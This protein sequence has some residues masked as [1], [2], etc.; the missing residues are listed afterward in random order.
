MKDTRF[1]DLDTDDVEWLVDQH[2]L[3]Y[4]IDQ[5]FDKT[6]GAMVREI[7]NQYFENHN[8]DRERSWVALQGGERVGTIFC[9]DEG[10]GVIQLRML[11]VLPVSRGS[12]LGRKLVGECV[13]FGREKGY[14]VMRLWT[15]K[16]LKAACALYE[17]AGFKCI[18]EEP[19]HAF[20]VDLVE[21]T[22]ELLLQIDPE[23]G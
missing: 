7:L 16:N 18:H 15:F 20:G 23:S 2:V 19:S 14:N 22:W 3:L 9:T 21:Q 10:S 6:F 8:P 4:E 1:R 5:G 17:S 13:N 11:L 12:G